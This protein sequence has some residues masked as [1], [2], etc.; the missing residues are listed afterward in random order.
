MVVLVWSVREVVRFADPEL[1]VPPAP[2]C[3]RCG[4]DVRGIAGPR[5]PE[6]GAH[7]WEVGV[8]GVGIPESNTR[9]ILRGVLAWGFL[10]LIVA[11]VLMHTWAFISIP[12][13]VLA[14]T[15]WIL[16][17]VCGYQLLRFARSR[18]PQK[19][20][21]L[22][23]SVVPVEETASPPPAQAPPPTDPPPAPTPDAP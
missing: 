21:D 13:I 20:I 4:F 3:G 19:R 22:I 2:S 10:M 11:E 14:A 16:V 18:N 12:T 7:L 17:T 15:T 6:C 5:C 1:G 23:Q 9:P 8:K